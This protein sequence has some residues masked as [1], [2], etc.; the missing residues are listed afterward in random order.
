MPNPVTGGAERCSGGHEV[1]GHCCGYITTT[2][3]PSRSG[4]EEQV[5]GH[6]TRHA[7]LLLHPAIQDEVGFERWGQS[8]L[9]RATRLCRLMV[10][11]LYQHIYIIISSVGL[12]VYYVL[13]SV[14]LY[15]LCIERTLDKI[16]ILTLMMKWPL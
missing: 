11:A 6:A 4:D 10:E 16:I 3:F 8:D 14:F 12:V 13:L 9:G 15:M 1:C 7:H 2:H 5:S